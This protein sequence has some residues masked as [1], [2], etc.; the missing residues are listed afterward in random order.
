MRPY[1]TERFGNPSSTGHSFGNDA[2]AAVLR[3]RNQLAALVG[4]EQDERT[5]AREIVFTSGATEANNLA[6]KGVLEAY[7][8]KGRHII[9]QV[10]EHRA[11]LETCKYMAEQHGC[12]VTF[13]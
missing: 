12:D 5:G 2:A 11:V 9:T 1:F 4:V 13:L 6:I 10:T 7:A 3:A 8:D